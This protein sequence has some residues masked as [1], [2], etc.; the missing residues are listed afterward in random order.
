[1]ELAQNLKRLPQ[2]LVLQIWSYTYSPQSPILL[3]DIRDYLQSLDYI[4]CYYLDKYIDSGYNE[5]MYW[6]IHDIFGYISFF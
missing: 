6:I 1:M 2:E 5:Y 4:Q 3:A